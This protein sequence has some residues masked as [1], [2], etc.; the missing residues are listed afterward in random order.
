M[1]EG[2]ENLRRETL[3]KR[4]SLHDKLRIEAE[5]RAKELEI[6][7]IASA[8][9]IDWDPEVREAKAELKKA[10]MS[11]GGPPLFTLTGWSWQKNASMR[12][13]RTRESDL[14]HKRK[15]RNHVNLQFSGDTFPLLF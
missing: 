12:L 5:K 2:L 1:S 9:P 8:D 3:A 4:K 13:L 14:T 6:G 11:L 10:R 15:A 7:V